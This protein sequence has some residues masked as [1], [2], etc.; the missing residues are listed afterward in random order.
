LDA[1]CGGSIRNKSNSISSTEQEIIVDK[2]EHELTKNESTGGARK[3]KLIRYL[4]KC[5]PKFCYRSFF[6]FFVV[7]IN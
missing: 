2:V 3:Q 6:C 4:C 1:I 7:T 5:D